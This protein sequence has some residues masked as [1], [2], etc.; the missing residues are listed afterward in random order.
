MLYVADTHSLIW[1]LTND[2]KLGNN[3]LGIFQK[4]DK[5]EDVIIIPTIVLAEVSY[6][7]EKKKA[8]IRFKEVIDKLK[9]SL[10][11][12]PYNLDL[13]I[14]QKTQDLIRIPELHDRIII[15]TAILVNAKILTKDDAIR[16]SG[17]IETIW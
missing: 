3:A 14:I 10:N 17:Y 9:N 1:F 6:I 5:G 11:Y 7:S 16:K 4:A 13:N 8:N 12:V 2:P 15:A